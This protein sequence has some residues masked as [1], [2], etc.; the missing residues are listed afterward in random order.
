MFDV[1]KSGVQFGVFVQA[2]K[3]CNFPHS[4]FR[5]FCLH[6]ALFT[7][8]ELII[9]TLRSVG[10][11]ALCLHCHLHLSA[12][13]VTRACTGCYTCVHWVLH[14]SALGVT[15]V[16]TG[17]YTCRHWVS[18]LSALGVTLVCTGNGC[19]VSWQGACTGIGGQARRLLLSVFRAPYT[20]MSGWRDCG[21]ACMAQ[22][23]CS[24]GCV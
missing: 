17:C 21:A 23:F 5:L 11:P 13:G 16:C 3:W 20:D 10:I 6:L 8:T 12:L 22:F 15:L 7:C 2:A 19:C 14:L 18:H 4:T 24:A 9:S 1:A